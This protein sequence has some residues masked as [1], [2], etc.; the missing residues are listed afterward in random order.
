MKKQQQIQ[1][2]LVLIIALGCMGGAGWL[3]FSGKKTSAGSSAVDVALY[4]SEVVTQYQKKS[5]LIEKIMTELKIKDANI[6]GILTHIPHWQALS[7][8]EVSE[9]EELNSHLDTFFSAHVVE[10]QAGMEKNPKLKSLM[11]ELSRL[12]QS[13]ADKRARLLSARL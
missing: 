3:Y 11:V 7:E 5:E 8:K 6:A 1:I 12:D 10:A 4:Q 2:A 13:I 9:I